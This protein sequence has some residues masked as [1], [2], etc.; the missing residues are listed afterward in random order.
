M[1]ATLCVNG[2]RLDLDHMTDEC[3]R[4]RQDVAVEMDGALGCAGGTRGKADDGRI[5][6]NRA[7]DANSFL[8]TQQMGRSVTTD[9]VAKMNQG[10]FYSGHC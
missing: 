7:G 9:S 2:V 3:V 1:T 8:V 6:G 5:V 4:R 10:R